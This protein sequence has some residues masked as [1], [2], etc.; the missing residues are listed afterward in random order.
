MKSKVSNKLTLGVITLS[1]HHV[2]A[3]LVSHILNHIGFEVASNG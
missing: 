2:A 3:S 1:F